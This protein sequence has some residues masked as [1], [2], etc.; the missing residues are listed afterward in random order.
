VG[1]MK[2]KLLDWMPRSPKTAGIEAYSPISIAVIVAS[3][4]KMLLS[5]NLAWIKPFT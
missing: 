3:L 1:A 5:K 2:L 4:S